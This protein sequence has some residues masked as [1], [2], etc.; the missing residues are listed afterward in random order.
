[1]A[2]DDFASSITRQLLLSRIRYMDLFLMMS[3]NEKVLAALIH[4]SVQT[5]WIISADI[6]AVRPCDTVQT[7]NNTF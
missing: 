7:Q 2:L 1:M 4:K 3:Q 5:T 6:R